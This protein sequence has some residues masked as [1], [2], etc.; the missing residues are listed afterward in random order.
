L[1]GLRDETVY[2]VTDLDTGQVQHLTG[3]ALMVEGLRV[4]ARAKPSA[5]LFLYKRIPHRGENE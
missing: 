2:T 3:R 1:R 4:T 5:S